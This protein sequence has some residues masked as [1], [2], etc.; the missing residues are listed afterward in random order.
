MPA[1]PVLTVMARWPSAGRC[2]RRLAHDLGS[3]PLQHAAERA[4]HLQQQLLIHTM[5][6]ANRLRLQGHLEL[7]IA[8]S[9]LAPRGAKRWGRS[10]H[11]DR[12]LLQHGGSL[13]CRLRHLLMAFRRSDPGRGLLLIGTD[14]PCLNHHDLLRAVEFLQHEDLVL[15]PADDGGYWLI[16]LSEALLRQPARWPIQDI[17]WGSSTVLESTIRRAQTAGLDPALIASRQDID[18]LSDLQPWLT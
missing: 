11:V 8:V 17:P 5:A 12:T 16:G 9:G 15:G 13:G 7:A 6:V 3:L 10:F 14:L 2:K 1:Q 4:A 18:R